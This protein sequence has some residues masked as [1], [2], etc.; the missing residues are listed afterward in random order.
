MIDRRA[1]RDSSISIFRIIAVACAICVLVYFIF[2]LVTGIE[3]IAT[4]IAC[5][6]LCIFL[7]IFIFGALPV[8]RGN[9]L[10]GLGHA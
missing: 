8:H 6:L 2:A 9:A 7:C 1:Q 3:P 5:A 10:G 4:V